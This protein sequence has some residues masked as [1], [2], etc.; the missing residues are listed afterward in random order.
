MYPFQFED[1]TWRID[2][3]TRSRQPHLTPGTEAYRLYQGVFASR[4][5]AEAAIEAVRAIMGA[6]PSSRSDLISRTLPLSEGA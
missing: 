1:G 5:E 6:T 4:R 2:F 3:L